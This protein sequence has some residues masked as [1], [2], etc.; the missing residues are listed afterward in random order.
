MENEKLMSILSRS[1]FFVALVFLAAAV[2]ANL[3]VGSFGTGRLVYFGLHPSAH[4]PTG[5]AEQLI[6]QAV[7][8]AGNSLADG[9]GDAC[10]PCPFDPD[11]DIDADG[12]CADADNCP[13]VPNPG[14]L[15]FWRHPRVVVSPHNSGDFF[16]YE[17]DLADLFLDN[18][19]RY[20]AGEPLRNLVDKELGF[21]AR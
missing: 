18:F 21:A 2:V 1:F 16:G 17:E 7:V 6:L 14:Q 19:K 9:L 10:D 12:F 15:A 3:L 11:D 13:S 20:Q 4:Q 5:Q 8:W